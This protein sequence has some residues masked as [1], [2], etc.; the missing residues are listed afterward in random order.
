MSN[1][2]QKKGPT[3][4]KPEE[5]DELKLASYQWGSTIDY[6]FL[7]TGRISKDVAQN[8]GASVP[9]VARYRHGEQ[10]GINIFLA[11][12]EELGGEVIVRVPK[13]LYIHDV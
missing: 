13:K 4:E 10:T 1:N 2:E 7:R 6:L 11:L 12:I 3:Q 5:Y 9:P 8:I